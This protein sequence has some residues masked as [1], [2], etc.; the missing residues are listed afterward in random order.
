MSASVSLSKNDWS[1]HRKGPIDQARHN[2]KVKEAIKDNLANIVGEEA[3]I[4]A[5]GNKIVKIPVRSLDLPHFRFDPGRKQHVGQGQ[6]GTRVGDVLG[7]EPSGQAGAGRGAGAGQEPGID[8]YEADITVD[9]LAALVFADLG[10][11]FLKP[12]GR[13]EVES[14]A[15]RYDDV[16]RR[17]IMSNLDKRRTIA[18]NLRRN[19]RT[20]RLGFQGL[21]M[22]DLRFKTWEKD[23]KYE[24]NAVVIAM[25]DV[26]GS[27]GEFE[28]YITRS[29]YFWMVRFLRTKY[30][31]VRIVFITHHR[32]T[33]RLSSTWV[34]RVAR[35]SRRPTSSRS[36][37]SKS[38]STRPS[39]TSTPFT[40]Q[41]GTTGARSTTSAASTWSISSSSA[42][43]FSVTGRSRKAAA[44]RLAP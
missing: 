39:G 23:V 35:R 37:S 24:T 26:S 2:E 20:G 22:D 13:Q 27:M 11:P 1:L 8:Y 21:S 41:T 34:S 36:T 5:D 31:H 38:G 30:N 29:F 7:H 33:R 17:G 42:A 14:E 18:E 4:T 32:L 16:R 43:T 28:K 3:I 15:V 44:A 6:G 10:L 12:K 19:A 25:R 9:E 40:S